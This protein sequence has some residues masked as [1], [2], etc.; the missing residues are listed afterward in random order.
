MFV[1]HEDAVESVLALADRAEPRADLF[2]A[3]PGVDEETRA[4]GGNEGGIAGAAAGQYADLDDV[5]S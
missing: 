4:I 1:R 3:E 5:S 2:P